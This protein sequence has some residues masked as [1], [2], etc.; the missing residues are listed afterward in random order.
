MR[1]SRLLLY[2]R[3]TDR[4]PQDRRRQH[5]NEE[6]PKGDNDLKDEKEDDGGEMGGDYRNH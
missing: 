6:D 5:L 1:R 2:Y 4:A 3:E